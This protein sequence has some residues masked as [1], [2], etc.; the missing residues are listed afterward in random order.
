MSPLLEPPVTAAA[1][2][3]SAKPIAATGL[4]LVV[5]AVDIAVKDRLVLQSL[6]RLLN[7]HG[8]LQL[9]YAE[10]ASECNVLFV[11][12]QWSRRAPPGCVAVHL[13]P[14]G[15][16]CD[17][18]APGLQVSSPLRMT[19]VMAV[20]TAAAGL[21][22]AGAGE[23]AG[24]LALLFRIIVDHCLIRERRTVSVALADG[25]SLVIDCAA[26][27]LSSPPSRVELLAHC[28][29]VGAVRRASPSEIEALR[30][31]PAGDLRS[32]I[33]AA[34]RRLGETGEPMAPPQG[35]YRLKRWPEAAALAAP[36]MPRLV[37]AWTRQHLTAA[38]AAQLAGRPL[39]AVA[40]FLTACMA[41]GLTEMAD[42]VPEAALNPLAGAPVDV[43]PAPPRGLVAR[44]RE[45]LR[46]W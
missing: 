40:W 1:A 43:P 30:A 15:A 23:H 31:G 46:L 38:E 42:T 25:R 24:P 13:L 7:Q 26:E 18:A 36:G 19:G 34:A 8:G 9:R 4:S 12:D 21:L 20:F 27:R 41:L 17:G 3:V 6:T 11:P 29:A 28:P 14:A 32:F 44:L 45:R 33:W 35:R 2:P 5:G 37:A 22:R 10:Q 39:G 16:A